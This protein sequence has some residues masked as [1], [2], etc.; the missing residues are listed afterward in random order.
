MQFIWEKDSPSK[1]KEILRSPDL[2]MLIREFI[3][4]DAPIKDINS[5]LGKVENILITAAKN[6]LRKKHKK[7]KSSSNKKWFDKEC[8]LKKHDLRKLS[9]QKHRDPLKANLRERYHTVLT[10]YKTPLCRKRTEY[11]SS[12]ITELEESTENPDKQRFWQC[13]KSMDD[14]RKEKHDL[15]PFNF[16]GNLA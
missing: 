3:I 5:A 6:A 9:N 15:S 10:E 4:D 1:F 13:L 11:Y 2:Q 7:I 8:R 12:K 16:G 14:T